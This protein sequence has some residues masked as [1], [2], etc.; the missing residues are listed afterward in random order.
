MLKRMF[1]RGRGATAIDPVCGMR[2]DKDD[3]P[4]GSFKPSGEQPGITYYF[5]GDGCRRAFEKNT[6]SFLEAAE[7]SASHSHA[8]HGESSSGMSPTAP[9]SFTAADDP[10]GDG[11]FV[12][13]AYMC[14]F[15]AA[16]PE[17][18]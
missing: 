13:V 1:G 5:C 2:V 3:P 8:G 18:G 10:S 14:V 9:I 16:L 6:A 7:G 17:P 4:G 11:K 12:D 15:T